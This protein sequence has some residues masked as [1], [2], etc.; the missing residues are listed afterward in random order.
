M[1]RTKGGLPKHCCWAVDR[2]GKRRVRFRKGGFSIYLTGI[3]WSEDF[4]RQY[5]S[6]LDGVKDQA[7]NIGAGR[8]IAGTVNALVA[9][10]LDCS[11]RSSSPFKTLAAETQRTRRTRRNIL[12]NFREAYGD[13]PLFRTDASGRR[14]MLLTREHMQRIVNEKS[15]TPFAQRNFLNTLRAVFQW[16]MVEG[17][18]PDDPTLGVKRRKVKTAGYKTW[19]E[20]EIARFEEKYPIGTKARLAFAA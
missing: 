4:M 11:D 16:A 9:A 10:Y 5:A 1:L 8:T 12:E 2:H 6:A 7:T 18:V 19:S 15:A 17:R 13:R 14:T 3:P 20:A